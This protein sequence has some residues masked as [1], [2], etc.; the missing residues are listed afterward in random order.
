MSDDLYSDS[1]RR[2]DTVIGQKTSYFKLIRAIAFDYAK[3]TTNISL[4]DWIVAS[5][6]LRI[7]RDNS[8]SIT[9]NYTIVDEQKYMMAIIKYGL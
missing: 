8:G 9:G 4:D 3:I 1:E 2:L 5:C 7:I 6:G